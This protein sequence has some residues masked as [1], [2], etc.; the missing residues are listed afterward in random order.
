MEV[1]IPLPTR[2]MNEKPIE[3]FR[4]LRLYRISRDLTDPEAPVPGITARD[5]PRKLDPVMTL[6]GDEAAALTPGESWRFR[7]AAE[8]LA[9]PAGGSRLVSYSVRFQVKGGRWSPFSTPTGLVVGDVI[10][11][12]REFIAG[13]GPRGVHLSWTEGVEGAAT[14]VYRTTPGA[15][16][17]FDPMTVIEAG[18]RQWVDPTVTVGQEYEY[19]IRT[20]VGEG[21][22][23]RLS[24]AAGPLRLAMEDTFAPAPPER[25]TALGRPGGVDLF[26][27]PGDEIDL[28]GYRVYR[29]MLPDGPWERL[30]AEHLTATTWVDTTVE[31]GERYAY[32]VSAV[33]FAEPPNESPRSEVKAVTVPVPPPPAEKVFPEEVAPPELPGAG[34][35]TPQGARPGRA[36]DGTAATSQGPRP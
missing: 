3:R 18:G 23:T 16:F 4:G 26:W 8:P 21:Q 11:P 2:L 30:T 20:L 32:A 9:A 7:E 10:S 27:S 15:L 13:P 29:R 6:S 28:A 33:D 17:P 14:A 25:L 31:P 22:R 5:F 12:P 36:Y 34:Q 1:W 35:D 24:A 19:A